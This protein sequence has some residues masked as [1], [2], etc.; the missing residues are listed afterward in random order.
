[1]VTFSMIRKDSLPDRSRPWGQAS[2][3]E[4]A[5]IEEFRRELTDF[6]L[7]DAVDAGKDLI[8]WM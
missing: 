6:F 4:I 5:L 1:M 2:S 3:A 7:L 8:H